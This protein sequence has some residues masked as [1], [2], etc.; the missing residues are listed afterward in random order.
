MTTLNELMQDQNFELEM[1]TESLER[2]ENINSRTNSNIQLLTADLRQKAAQDALDRGEAASESSGSEKNKIQPAQGDKENSSF[3]SSFGSSFG[4][5]AGTAAGLGALGLGIGAFFGGL[6]A[7]DAALSYM[8]TDMSG[9]KKAMVGLGE[10]FEATPTKGLLAMGVLLTAGGAM[11][12][13]L[14]PG[15]SMKAGFGMFMLGAGIG[16]F[17]A[18]LAAGSAGIDVLNTDGSGLKSMMQNVGEGLAAFVGDPGALAALGGLLAAGALFGQAPGA[19]V[20]GTLGI[21]LIGLGIGAFFAGIATGSKAIQ[22]LG[23]DGSGIRNVMV[24]TAEGLSALANVKNY[25][26][27]LAFLPAAA[28]VTAGMALLLGSEGLS[29]VGKGVANL[30]GI[31]GNGEE[32]VYESLA[33]GL[34][35]LMSVDYSNITELA[36]AGDAVEGLGLGFQAL[37]ETDFSDMTNNLEELGDAAGFM[38]PLLERMW[39]GGEFKVESSALGFDTSKE[40]NF[41]RG[42]RSIP[43]KHI[44]KT[45]EVAGQIGTQP[46]AERAQTIAN[47]TDIQGLGNQIVVNNNTN[48]PTQVNTQVASPTPIQLSNPTSKNG[49]IAD[50][51]TF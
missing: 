36:A 49:S 2:L 39:Q 30:L 6:A 38:I 24:N 21:G 16:G 14:G 25:S 51:Y 15:G 42:L 43:I 28:S 5:L 7:G 40:Y 20:K 23:A 41:G 1:Q 27:L 3:A 10:A 35:E 45:F 13:L 32:T 31:G 29:S 33:K 26:N 48:A 22:L 34:N 47:N 50:E 44:S 17:F 46:N 18:G 4:G 12:A 37:A 8:D 19:A 9:L 11:G